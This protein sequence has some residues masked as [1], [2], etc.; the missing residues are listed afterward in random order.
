MSKVIYNNIDLRFLYLEKI[1][2][3]FS[4]VEVQGVFFCS[5][6]QLTSLQGAPKYVGDDFDCYNNQLTSLQ[7]APEEVGGSFY[8]NSNQLT[9]L[10]G[11]PK[12]V[13]GNFDC[14]NNQL[15]SLQGAPKY[16]GGNFVCYY[17]AVKFTEEQVRAVC[18]VKGKVVAQ[19]KI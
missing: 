1:P 3:I 10:Q 15:T 9:S 8:C 12:Y 17:N 14:G 4:G 11:A 19:I 5:N 7:G 18:Q 13:G 6:N 2:D 16:V